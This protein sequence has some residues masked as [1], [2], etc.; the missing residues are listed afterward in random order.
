[1]KPFYKGQNIHGT[2][3]LEPTVVRRKR[4]PRK[5]WI[6]QINA[7][8]ITVLTLDSLYKRR[9]RGRARVQPYQAGVNRIYTSYRYRCKT[10]NI[11]FSISVEQFYKLS[12]KRCVYCNA[13]PANRERGFDFIYNG[14][15]RK[16]NRKGY[17]KDN[18]L[19]CCGTCNS[20]K[21]NILTYDEMVAA[22]RAILR[23]R[24]AKGSRRQG[25]RRVRS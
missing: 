2:V 24:A 3:L 23:V 18:S 19:P 15:D 6:C 5:A 1:M 14:L 10:R 25:Q 22:M 9:R 12:Q 17:T 4:G 16:D 20:L 21:S 11:F 13:A 8:T 7:E